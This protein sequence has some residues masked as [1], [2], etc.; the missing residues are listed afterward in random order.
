M[1]TSC[2]YEWHSVMQV[3]PPTW[4]RRCTK[5]LSVPW[6][7]RVIVVMSCR[8]CESRSSLALNALVPVWSAFELL[9]CMY[10]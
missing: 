9:A 8:V 6:L 5:A 4:M 2:N 1:C 10:L 7:R 3:T